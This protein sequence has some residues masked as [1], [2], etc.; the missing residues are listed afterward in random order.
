MMKRYV[1]E[2]QAAVRVLGVIG[3]DGGRIHFEL[4]DAP[5]IEEI[6]K[7]VIEARDQQHHPPSCRAVAQ[8]PSHLQRATDALK[9][10][11]QRL[12]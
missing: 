1:D 11:A 4:A 6:R 3:D 8:L 5:A 2:M 10:F 12:E 9:F 7:A